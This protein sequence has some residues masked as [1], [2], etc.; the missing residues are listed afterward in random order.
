[1]TMIVCS[2]PRSVPLLS[3]ISHSVVFASESVTI[4]TGLK[5]RTAT[6]IHSQPLLC[7]WPLFMYLISG[8]APT[9]SILMSPY[10]NHVCGMHFLMHSYI[11]LLYEPIGRGG[12]PS[13]WEMYADSVLL[14]QNSTMGMELKSRLR[15][16]Y[17]SRCLAI[18]V[19]VQAPED[20]RDVLS[21]LGFF[22]S[23]WGTFDT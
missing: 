17:R 12:V 20:S 11:S 16:L 21:A 3:F 18:L 15:A 2:F 6:I 19:V 13:Y 10:F 8:N 9:S 1:M 5:T 14:P 4:P 23:G 22:N 7:L